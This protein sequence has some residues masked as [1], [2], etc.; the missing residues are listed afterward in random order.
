MSEFFNKAERAL[1]EQRR[2]WKGEGRGICA[3]KKTLA[4][5]FPAVSTQR[6]F[7]CM[8]LSPGEPYADAVGDVCDAEK[9]AGCDG[10]PKPSS[11]L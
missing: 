7:G 2:C 6:T 4:E 5:L 1:M 10:E 3:A 8:F 11:M 9:V